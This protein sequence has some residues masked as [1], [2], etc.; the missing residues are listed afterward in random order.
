MDSQYQLSADQVRA[1][2][3]LLR[4]SR[5]RLAAKANLSETTISELE[6]GARK[7][8]PRTVAAVRR[9]FEGGGILFA[10]EGSP[11]LPYPEGPKTTDNRS[12]RRRRTDSA[13]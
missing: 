12:R 2:R 8:H 11:S 1:A 13:R 9:A 6:N 7:P 5:V 10:A 4:W 3:A